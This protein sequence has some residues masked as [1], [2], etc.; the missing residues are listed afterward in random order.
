MAGYFPTLATLNPNTVL[1]GVIYQQSQ[2]S[3][4][5]AI[6]AGGNAQAKLSTG[7]KAVYIPTLDMR[8]DAKIG[9][10]PTYNLPSI[11]ISVDRVETPVY[12][13]QSQAVYSSHSMRE[14]SRLNVSLV[15]ALRVS[16]NQTFSILQRNIG[17]NGVKSGSGEGILGAPGVT[18]ATVPASSSSKISIQGYEPNEFV[19]N[20]LIP[21]ISALMT[22]T[23]TFGMLKRITILTS[24]RVLSKL[25]LQGKLQIF[26]TT[27]PG[28]GVNTISQEL[29]QACSNIGCTLEWATDDTLNNSGALAAG[30]AKK[31]RIVITCPEIEFESTGYTNAFAELGNNITANNLMLTNM[32]QPSETPG[33]IPGNRTEIIYEMNT[34]AGWNIRPQLTTIIEMPYVEAGNV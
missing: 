26:N 1:P 13:M 33:P 8:G 17:L 32:A 20:V 11:N 12:W 21:E 9:M 29:A 23:Y 28:T 25:Q 16:N 27:M 3:G 15:D 30:G 2:K 4:F 7:D 34:T 24:A 10:S 19:Y 6:L 14:A 22:R 18:L 5:P 31:D